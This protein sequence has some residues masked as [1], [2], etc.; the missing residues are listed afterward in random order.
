[1]S[2]TRRKRILVGSR[3]LPVSIVSNNAGE[4]TNIQS[5]NFSSD[6]NSSNDIKVVEKGLFRLLTT[7]QRKLL[8]E[9]RN[10]QQLTRGLVTRVG[11]RPKDTAGAGIGGLS[12]LER[13]ELEA[14][15]SVVV[16]GEFNAG[17]STLLNAL[18]GDKLLE[19]GSLPTTDAITIVTKG[20]TTTTTTHVEKSSTEDSS[21]PLGVDIRRIDSLTQT[22]TDDSNN[23]DNNNQIS[24]DWLEDLTLIDTPGTNSAWLD[25]TA[26]T[27]RLLPEA[28]LIFFV[29]SADRPFSESERLLLT[30]IQ[31][32]RKD[33][34]VLVNKMDI[35]ETTGGDHGQQAKAATVDFVT[36]HA[37]ELLG[38]RPIVIPISSRDALSAKVMQQQKQ[39]QD[40]SYQDSNLW[41]RSNFEALES[42]LKQTLTTESKLRSK[43][44]S[45]LGVVEGS[46]TQALTIL[47][48]E[49]EALETDIATLNLLNSQFDGWK[50]EL[51]MDLQ[52]FRRNITEAV[53]GEGQRVAI[54]LDTKMSFTTFSMWWTSPILQNASNFSQEWTRARRKLPNRG[55]LQGS[56]D[57]ESGDSLVTGLLEVVSE[58]A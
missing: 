16:C 57:K 56:T 22:Q 33:I 50:K 24:Y 38:A 7:E 1:M 51:D 35:L 15:F 36:D 2:S 14:H 18:L 9:Q 27:L 58:T 4:S 40:S 43:L 55:Y 28:D 19:S 32:Y 49:N 39:H 29:T 46:L 10:L 37:S 47:K 41:K 20:D 17:K 48:E 11:I 5:R 26:Q 52:A 6:E 23:N 25:H 12:F 3:A 8:D 44:V 53:Q 30:K 21:T 45:P 31:H 13:L 34:V 42:F 54:L